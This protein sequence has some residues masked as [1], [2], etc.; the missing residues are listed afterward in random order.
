[1]TSWLLKVHKHELCR[2]LSIPRLEIVGERSCG[3]YVTCNDDEDELISEGPVQAARERHAA[4]EELVKFSVT[5]RA[6]YCAARLRVPCYWGRVRQ[7]CRAGR[8]R[9][10]WPSLK[11]RLHQPALLKHD[12]YLQRPEV[13]FSSGSSD[14]A[15]LYSKSKR[16]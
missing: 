15:S 16:G 4:G 9:G 6:T 7:R 14:V 5:R 10:H 8:S 13:F 3:W 2:R 12:I 1:M 11:T